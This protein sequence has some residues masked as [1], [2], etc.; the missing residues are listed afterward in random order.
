MIILL[1][2][3][4][5]EKAKLNRQVHILKTELIKAENMRQPDLKNVQLQI[6]NATQELQQQL[7]DSQYQ[8]ELLK[9]T[10]E[11]NQ[12]QLKVKYKKKVQQIQT[13][14]Q[15]MQQELQSSQNFRV[16]LTLQKD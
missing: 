12:R 4:D 9:Q 16:K 1:R 5:A 15:K 14:N 7:K 11:V 13:E 2:N 3:N 8:M 6:E 10:N